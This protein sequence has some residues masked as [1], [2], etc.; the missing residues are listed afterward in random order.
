MGYQTIFTEE[1]LNYLGGDCILPKS[2]STRLVKVPLS[3][4]TSN[5]VFRAITLIEPLSL[6]HAAPSLGFDINNLLKTI[7]STLRGF[8]YVQEVKTEFSGQDN[9]RVLF[10]IKSSTGYTEELWNKAQS[11]VINACMN[12]RDI[13]GEKF[14]F[15]TEIVE[16][17]DSNV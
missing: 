16:D 6:D 4:N 9:H 15:Y 3:I 5:Q 13:T 8:K 7:H 17:F 12:L 1:Q 14:Y 2:P 10:R 11:I